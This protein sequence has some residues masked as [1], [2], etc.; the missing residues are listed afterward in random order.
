[1][2]PSCPQ[3]NDEMQR[4]I[5]TFLLIVFASSCGESPPTQQVPSAESAVDVPA[6]DSPSVEP[7]AK[8][9]SGESLSAVERTTRLEVGDHAPNF[10]LQ[11]QTGAE[12][13]L[14]SLLA[15]GKVALVFHR[16]ADW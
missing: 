1:M 6:V 14:E 10:R 9:Q 11:D 4:L 16:S 2:G 8:P 3:S 13:T 12:H 7:E 5:A 15:K